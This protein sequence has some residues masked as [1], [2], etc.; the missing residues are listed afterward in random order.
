MQWTP[1]QSL[2]SYLLLLVADNC[3]IG[4]L[5]AIVG[6]LFVCKL[7]YRVPWLPCFTCRLQAWNIGLS[8]VG[9]QRLVGV[10]ELGFQQ[11]AA[12]AYGRMSTT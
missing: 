10:S 2:F 5:G 12:T 11:L 3:C 4:E 8:G 7:V 6:L 9:M 1:S